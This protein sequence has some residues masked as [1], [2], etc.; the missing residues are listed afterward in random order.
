MPVFTA[1]ALTAAG[2]EL[3]RAPPRTRPMSVT[4]DELRHDPATTRLDQQPAPEHLPQPGTRHI[5]RRRPTMKR[6]PHPTITPRWRC[7]AGGRRYGDAEAAVTATS[8]RSTCTAGARLPRAHLSGWRRPATVPPCGCPAWMWPALAGHWSAALVHVG[9]Q[10]PPVHQRSNTSIP[11]TWI[12]STSTKP[13][14]P[15]GGRVDGMRHGGH[16]LSVGGPCPGW[17][18][19]ASRV[20]RGHRRA[21]RQRRHTARGDRPRRQ[22]Y[23]RSPALRTDRMVADCLRVCRALVPEAR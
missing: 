12:R 6:E 23:P 14:G 5:P 19:R 22:P 13:F 1:P 18:R 20:R 11:R 21:C 17:S 7:D 2:Q 10:E 4:I 8:R 15:I 9:R 16:R 3:W